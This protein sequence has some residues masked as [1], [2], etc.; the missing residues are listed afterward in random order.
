M[1][2]PLDKEDASFRVKINEIEEVR[3]IF[4]FMFSSPLQGSSGMALDRSLLPL[5]T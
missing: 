1:D 5:I 2:S 3:A 4:D